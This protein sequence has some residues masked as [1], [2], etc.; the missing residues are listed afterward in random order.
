MPNN[1]LFSKRATPNCSGD[2]GRAAGDGQQ[3]ALTQDHR[4]HVPGIRA[5]RH[6][7][8]DLRGPAHHHLRHQ[9]EDPDRGQQHRQDRE[10]REQ[11]RLESPD[12][13]RLADFGLDGAD[14]GDRRRRIQRSNRRAHRRHESDRWMVAGHEQLQVAA[15]ELA[16]GSKHLQARAPMQSAAAHVAGHADNRDPRIVRAR[17]AEDQALADRVLVRP[18]LVRKRLV[19]HDRRRAAFLVA[20]VEEPAMHQAHL[21]GL[22]ETGRD[23]I[24]CRFDLFRRWKGWT[25]LEREGAG[26]RR[27]A[28]EQIGG[29]GG[30]LDTRKGAH[31]RQQL[32]V[33]LN[34]L[35]SLRVLG[36]RRV[37]AHR[38]HVAGTKARVHAA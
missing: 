21:H 1:R 32:I 7:Q 18:V 22:E 27:V 20:A 29:E 26:V 23:E 30:A 24:A 17:A 34:Q 2:A 25:I 19:D 37:D 5:E 16:G 38:Q 14:L 12:G 4:E 9:S 15:A 11:Q 10:Q 8:P 6:A 33:E 36:P 35:W 13:E 31:T 28:Q 3:H